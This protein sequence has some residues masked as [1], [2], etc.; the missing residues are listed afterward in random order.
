MKVHVDDQMMGAFPFLVIIFKYFIIN[1]LEIKTRIPSISAAS[2]TLIN[3]NNCHIL[4]TE[5]CLLPVLCLNK[6]KKGHVAMSLSFL[7]YTLPQ[8]LAEKFAVF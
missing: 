4:A 7:A 1:M 3:D 6:K 8:V 5:F 2:A